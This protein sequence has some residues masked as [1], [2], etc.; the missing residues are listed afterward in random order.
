MTLTPA[1]TKHLRDGELFSALDRIAHF[2]GSWTGEA[3]DVFNPSTGELLASLPDMGIEQASAA[4]DAAAAA[5]TLWAAKPAK[6]RS[7][8][9]RR[10]HDLIIAH[11]DDLAAILTAEMG[12]PVG[13]SKGEVLH[14]A[15]YVEWYAEEAKRIYGETFPAPANDRRMLVIKQPVGV[16]GT[17]TPWN[18]P[19]SMVARK[20][21]PALAAGCAIVLK[22]A[23]Q[24]PLVAGALFVLA[25]KA[26]FPAGVVNLLYA[27]EGAAIGRELCSNPK[28][29]KISFTGSTE[30]GR[31]LMRQCSD[32]IKKV[33]LELGGNAPFIVFDDADIDEAVDGAVQAKFRNAGQTCVSANRIYVQS[34]VHDA[35]AEK[36]VARVAELSV[37]D[38]FSAGVTIGPMIDRH[39]IEKI[40]AHVADAVSKG[41]E[42]RSGGHRI[43]TS[44]TFFEPTV[45]TGISTD[46]RIAQEETFGPI[47]PIIRFETAEQVIAEAND[48]IYGL[49][50][51]FY[52]ENLKRVW[53]VAEALEYGMVGINTGR[54]SSEAAPF[55]GIKQSGIGREGSRHGLEDY[56]EM[57][58]LC[59]GNI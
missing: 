12:K 49:A 7:A 57:K 16:V 54:M 41:A 37:G 11:A 51:Y 6:D 10:W 30:V 22:P 18:F 23:E 33:S 36:F 46:M 9:L 59:M 42:V 45:L 39:A 56:L 35:F 40:E 58:Y 26:G 53:H 15:A 20:I 25:E 2:A 34:A 4:I 50:A 17:I 48:T 29:R 38:G 5:Q 31:L 3:F 24:T 44:G 13:E 19:A 8:V 55:G 28:V 1:L 47:A 52:A 21:A 32:Q 14:A 43:G 27:S